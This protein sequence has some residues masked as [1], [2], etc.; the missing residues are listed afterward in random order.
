MPLPGQLSCCAPVLESFSWKPVTQLLKA[1]IVRHLWAGMQEWLTQGWPVSHFNAN[2]GR[3]KLIWTMATLQNFTEFAF[4]LFLAYQVAFI[5]AGTLRWRSSR[6]RGCSK[7]WDSLPCLCPH[8]VG[9]ELKIMPGAH[10]H[11]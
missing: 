7:C 5:L 6:Y 11:G 8:L 2:V 4:I 10:S 9:K 3:P 1:V